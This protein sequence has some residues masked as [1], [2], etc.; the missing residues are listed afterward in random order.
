MK[1]INRTFFFFR[2]VPMDDYKFRPRW[3]NFSPIFQINSRYTYILPEMSLNKKGLII[4]L[5]IL[6]Y[7]YTTQ[8]LFFR[9]SLMSS[10][11]L[12]FIVTDVISYC[13]I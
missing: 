1:Y 10:I 6:F 9:F 2:R 5:E 12:R 7:R 13:I 11:T 8:N 4:T 3:V